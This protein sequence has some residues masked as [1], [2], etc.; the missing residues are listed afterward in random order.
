MAREWVQAQLNNWARWLQQKSDGGLGYP[1]VNILQ[2]QR[3]A[4]TDVDV[5][6]VNDVQA[7]AVHRAVTAL[8]LTSSKLYVAICCRYVGSP[9]LPM[10]RRTQMN[11][12]D[13]AGLVGVTDRTIRE[14]ITEGEDLVDATLRRQGIEG[15]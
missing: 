8:Q 3:G 1:K 12:A 2:M 4:S 11:P 5:V 10:R 7:E 14:W 13:I 9:R 15:F 6:P